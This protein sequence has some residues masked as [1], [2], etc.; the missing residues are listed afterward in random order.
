MSIYDLNAYEVIREEDLSDLKSKGI[1]LKHKKSQA[2]I[3]LFAN[4]D[5]NK[6]FTIGFRTPAPDSTGVPHIMEHSV[7]CGSKNF[8]VKDPFV[9]LVKG[10][11]NTF[12][13]AMT[14]PDKT[15]YPVASCNSKD[16]QNL[17]HVYMDAVFY[18]N[19]YEHDEIFRQEGW[20]YKLDTA[21]GKLEY[22]GVV[23]NEMKGAFSSPEGVLDRVIQNSLFPDTS[24]ANESGGD[25]DVIPEL[26]Y[27]QFLNFHRTY[28]HP[29]NSYIYL[30]G[31]M[32][33][34]EKLRWLDENYLSAFDAIEVDS[35]IKYQKPF[36]EIRE[37]EMEYSISSEESEEDNTYLS[38]NKVIGTS[39]DEK[40]YLAFQIL[41]Y[42]LLSAPG[43]PLKK[44]LLD[45]GIGKDISGS[46]DSSTYQPIFSIVAKNANE[47]Q[48]AEFVKVIEDTLKGIVEN[49]MDKKALEAGINYHEF[50]YR[51]ADFGGYPKGL[52]YGLQIFDSWLYDET[53]PFIH[54][55]ALD[56][57]AFLK[58]Q[59]ST[60]YFEKLIQTYLLDNQHGALVTIVPE[61]GRTARLD[62]ELKEKLQAYKES[63][64]RGEIEKLVTDT[65]HL[66]EYQEEPSSQEDL[67]KIP[68]LTREDISREI[69]PIYNEEMKIA[70]IPTVF[71]EIETNGIGYL[72]LMFDLSDVPE[73]DLPMV[74]L[75]QAVLGIIDTEHYEYGELFNE[76]NRHTGGIGTSLE[77]YPDVTKVK[78]KEFKATFEIKGKALYGQIPFAIRMMKEILTASKLDDEKRLKEILSMTKTRLQDRF[79]SAGHSAAALRAM[80]YKSPISKFKDTTNGIE[81]YQNI[82]EME[83][84]F[85]EKKE[86]IISGLKALSELLFRKGNVM[87]SYTASR[88]GLAVLE[89]EIGS[90]KEALYP[91]RMPQSRCILHCEKKNEGFKTSSKVQFAA[92]AGNFIDAGEEYNGALQI[93]KV[94]MSYEYLWIN[95]RVKG[96]AYGCMSGIGRSG[97]GYFVSYRDPE[98]KKSDD[99]YLGIPDYLENFEADERTMTKYVIGTISDIDTPL[100]PSLKGSRGLSAWYSGVTDEM[101][102]KEREEILNATV[103]DIRALAP[104]TKAVLE[105]GAV[106]VVGN[107]DK[108]KA[109]RELFKEIKPL[110][111]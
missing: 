5:E 35:E 63:L 79:L 30:Y 42:A 84:H 13:N 54:V 39:L 80:S 60:G 12:L 70:D 36:E 90:L 108:I 65:K 32:D 51:E 52:M 17:M 19:I 88:E 93:L 62:A 97:E 69:A 55:E 23:Y 58:E 61:P 83:E 78:E 94:I 100:T 66:Q 1:L 92:K 27:E 6:V 68:M 110:F 22:N 28:Y 101:M 3:L 72:D 71:H 82:R 33:M 49:G 107:E 64:S 16:F 18:P 111:E 85:D 37:L 57:F 4:D 15:L 26:T 91:E 73:K 109:D 53:K 8:P 95:I 14:Y 25:P 59:I 7:L 2:K 86:E 102:K 87:I 46:Y 48:K 103:E 31:D 75:L 9:E 40:L 67:E 44:A 45:A 34:E 21:D 41:D 56:T 98:V 89:E 77:L 29:S 99:I 38:Y 74:G 24:Y 11:L 105:T 10:S 47:E 50:R 106:C 81:Y 43:A 96:G 20:S 76:I 104:I